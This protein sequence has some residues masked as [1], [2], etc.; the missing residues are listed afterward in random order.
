MAKDNEY[1]V[2]SGID[3][4]PNKRAE[5][6]EVVSDLPK[7]AISW[8]LASGVIELASSSKTD[9]VEEVVEAVI[10]ALSND[11]P[12]MEEDVDGE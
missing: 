12:L 6:G 7:D 5:A 8:L 2:L 11:L 1:K 10:E 9:S 4:P 3:Y